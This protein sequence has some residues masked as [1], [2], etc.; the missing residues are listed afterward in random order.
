[1]SIG[2]GLCDGSLG[3]PCGFTVLMLEEK[4]RRKL[5]QGR[6]APVDGFNVAASGSNV[7]P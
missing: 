1:M 2:I 6:R 5:G 7:E 4:E 3:H